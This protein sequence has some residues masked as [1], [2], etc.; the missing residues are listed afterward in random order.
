MKPRRRRRKPIVG[1]R[2]I[3][4]RGK[5]V[6]VRPPQIYAN[7]YR[8]SS[9]SQRWALKTPGEIL[10]EPGRWSITLRSRDHVSDLDAWNDAEN[11]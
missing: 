11:D 8:I 4:V 2:W 7:T 1:G 10:V 9:E 6:R 3:T 5:P